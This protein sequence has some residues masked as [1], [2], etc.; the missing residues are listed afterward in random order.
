[1]R[2]GE[3]WCILSKNI[4]LKRYTD[5]VEKVSI[6]AQDIAKQLWIVARDSGSTATKYTKS[7]GELI[8]QVQA[9]YQVLL[10]TSDSFAS[11][12][13]D[14]QIFSVNGRSYSN[15]H[16]AAVAEA[17]I[18]LEYLWIKLDKKDWEQH[19]KAWQKD[20]YSSQG[21]AFFNG[22]G[23][24]LELVRQKQANAR[25]LTREALAAWDAEFA[26]KISSTINNERQRLSAD[27]ARRVA[28]AAQ[29]WISALADS[30]SRTTPDR[31]LSAK[32]GKLFDELIKKKNGLIKEIAHHV[33]EL[34]DGRQRSGREEPFVLTPLQED[35]LR[36]LDKRAMK[37][38]ALADEV[39]GGEG[40]RLYRRGGIKELRAG[41]KV[42]HTYGAGYFRPDAPPPS[43]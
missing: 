11:V 9:A 6:C 25:R 26:P 24:K 12:W 16:I 13:E 20:H 35:I 17:R 19:E 33:H 37:K 2:S 1:M 10:L 3:G 5:L 38:Q 8:Q 21:Q 30:K 31:I 32:S 4:P 42:G 15:A 14:G 23:L 36:A 27:H 7:V 29:P 22:T 40:T 43:P 34:V 18:F 28:L 41:G 39:C